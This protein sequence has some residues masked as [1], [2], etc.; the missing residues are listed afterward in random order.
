[1]ETAVA[2]A[3]LE[4]YLT[5][6]RGVDIQPVHLD[7]CVVMMR[8]G[9]FVPKRL[10]E[11]E[12]LVSFSTDTM[13]GTFDHSGEIIHRRLV[14][15]PPTPIISGHSDANNRMTISEEWSWSDIL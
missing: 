8:D 15:V 7:G 2:T 12:K 9:T 6:V 13:I 1:M 4:Y 14:N 10:G 3:T 11:N 5:G